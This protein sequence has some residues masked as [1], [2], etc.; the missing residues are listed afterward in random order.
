MSHNRKAF[1]YCPYCRAEMLTRQVMGRLRQVCPDCGYI[2]FWIPKWVP[3]SWWKK[4]VQ[5]YW[6]VERL[7][8][9]KM[10]GVCLPAFVEYDE[11]PQAARRPRVLRRNRT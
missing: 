9:K 11:A 1:L 3:A 8:H 4:M 5:S 7:C 10:S 6:F 2:H